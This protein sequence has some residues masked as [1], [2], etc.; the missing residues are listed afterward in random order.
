MDKRTRQ[1]NNQR[2]RHERWYSIVMKL[3]GFEGLINSY[4]GVTPEELR[5]MRKIH[6]KLYECSVLAKEWLKEAESIC[7][8]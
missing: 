2:K 3:S 7:L 1:Y 4:D 5:A 8:E 6:R